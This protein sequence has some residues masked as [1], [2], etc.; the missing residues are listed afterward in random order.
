[1]KTIIIYKSNT[2]FTKQYAELLVPRIEAEGM[3]PIKNISKKLL[4]DK[5][6]IVFMG[7]LRNNVILGL[8]KFLKYYKRDLKDKNIFIFA[9]GIQPYSDEKK[10]NVIMSNNLDEYHV[11][12]YFVKGGMSIKKMGF[13]Q[14]KM[15]T[16]GIKNAMKENPQAG[17]ILNQDVNMV[18]GKELDQM[19]NVYYKVNRE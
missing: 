8:K 11:R 7:P 4:K 1:M 18:E 19:V 9:N 14:R 2:G 3:Y 10:E 12:L 17:F 5:K 13:F 15:L 16:L 6:N